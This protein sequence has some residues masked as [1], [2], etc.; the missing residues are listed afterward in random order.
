MA[1]SM[2]GCS[3]LLG[4][5][6]Y[7]DGSGSSAASGVGG[8][9]VGGAGT[10]ASS[11]GVTGGAASSSGNGGTAGAGAA[12]FSVVMADDPVAYWRLNE[13]MALEPAQDLAND[14]DGVY[15]GGITFG[16][17]ALVDG[18]MDGAVRLDGGEGSRIEV[19]DDLDFASKAPFSIE[20]WIKLETVKTGYI[21]HKMTNDSSLNG[22]ELL[23]DELGITFAR[24]NYGSPASAELHIPVSV[25]NVHHV[26]G[27]YDGTQLCAYLDTEPLCVPDGLELINSDVP[28]YLGQSLEGVLDEVVIYNGALPEARV[29]AHYQAGIR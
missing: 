21:V 5:D 27:A 19:E 3:D 20:A 18:E 22:Y 11:A 23:V 25:A 24:W 7:A 16:K 15:L 17:S 1:V 9:G 26:V 4:F 8:A 6:D 13:S 10:N 2:V 29:I 12:Y 14:Y 28:L